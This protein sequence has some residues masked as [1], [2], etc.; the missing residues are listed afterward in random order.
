MKNV[1]MNRLW[2]SVAVLLLTV[3]ISGFAQGVA[4]IDYP[5]VVMLHPLMSTYHFSRGA[6]EKVQVGI[7]EQKYQEWLARAGAEIANLQTKYKS[8]LST[9]K[10]AVQRLESESVRMREKFNE[11]LN[12]LSVNFDRLRTSDKA[13]DKA[14][15]ARSDYQQKVAAF[16]EKFM[17]ESQGLATQL[18]KA[19]QELK[20]LEALIEAPRWTTPAETK[21]MFSRIETDIAAAAQQVMRG[22][23]CSVL[24]N[25][26]GMGWPTPQGSLEKVDP[27]ELARWSDADLELYKSFLTSD[28]KPP[29][30]D[31]PNPQYRSLLEQAFMRNKG[32]MV[33]RA[34]QARSGL[35]LIPEPDLVP[36]VLM[37]GTNVT[38]DV[39]NY[40]LY[41]YKLTD[42][43]R[44]L[45]AQVLREMG[46]K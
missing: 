25:S 24:L 38:I 3:T 8:E 19:R 11:T 33:R 21:Q 34:L 7:D 4:V 18:E 23:N 16:E 37:G 12:S 44:G 27:A 36:R 41:Q 14:L 17:R 9:R 46:W 45:V 15:L 2:A 43:Q 29:A 31:A 30:Q 40:I 20:D 6:F 26:G 28:L 5:T 39:V 35:R 10:A 42:A 1:T 13:E 22:K 32:S